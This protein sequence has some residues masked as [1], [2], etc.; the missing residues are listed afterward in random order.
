MISVGS[1]VCLKAERVSSYPKK[2]SEF[3]D[4]VGK[5]INPLEFDFENLGSDEC[6][7]VQYQDRLWSHSFPIYHHQLD[8][9]DL[10]EGESQ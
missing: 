4:S 1:F 3:K 5:I 10:V 8:D 2:H 6:I 9:F 7:F